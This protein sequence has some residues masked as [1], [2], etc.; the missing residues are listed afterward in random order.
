MK[1]VILQLWEES[2]KDGVIQPDGCS[3]H[4]DEKSLKQ[5]ISEFYSSRTEDDVPDFY[6]R[7]IGNPI[8]VDVV[9]NIYNIISETKSIRIQQYEMNNL[10]GLKE[11]NIDDI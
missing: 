5:F 9:E 8:E 10:I 2:E 1:K 3:L 4:F 6:E 7:V 11:I